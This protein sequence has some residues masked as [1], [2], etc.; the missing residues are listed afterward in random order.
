MTGNRHLVRAITTQ[1]DEMVKLQCKPMQTK[2]K[3]EV[4]DDMHQIK[5]KNGV[6]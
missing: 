4:T 1:N 3:V 5:V 2:A 6:R